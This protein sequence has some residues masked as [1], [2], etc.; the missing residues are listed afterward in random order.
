MRVEYRWLDGTSWFKPIL[1]LVWDLV[2]IWVGTTNY[3][4]GDALIPII[5]LVLLFVA[6]YAALALFFNST[7]QHQS[8]GVGNRAW[9]AT[10]VR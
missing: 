3:L 4:R 8:D 10:L 9:A 7:T 5:C 1:L 2:V 6:T